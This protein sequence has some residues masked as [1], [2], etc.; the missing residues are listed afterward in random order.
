MGT[1]PIFES[2]FDCLTKLL[3]MNR[4]LSRAP[5]IYR[6]IPRR[7]LSIGSALCWRG[8]NDKTQYGKPADS[9]FNVT[10]GAVGTDMENLTRDPTVKWR[11]L[12]KLLFFSLVIG[13]VIF[14]KDK[15]GM[16]AY[17]GYNPYYTQPEKINPYTN[18]Q[19][20]TRL[21]EMQAYE[22]WKLEQD[23]K[24]IIKEMDRVESESSESDNNS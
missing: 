21:S 6:I 7:E 9:W 1:H 16:R 20:A 8:G 10:P 4:L 14:I 15:D 5:V 19:G 18:A 2:D 13:I 11:L 17:P 24:L 22:L 12:F 3:I 23:A